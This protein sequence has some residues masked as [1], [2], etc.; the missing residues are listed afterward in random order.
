MNSKNLTEVNKAQSKL[1]K[2]LLDMI[3][4]Q[5]LE[6]NSMHGYQLITLSAKTSA[7]T[8]APAPYIRF[9]DN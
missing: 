4:L 9:L 1:A 5:Y 7:S 2:G 3:I 8:S 6:K